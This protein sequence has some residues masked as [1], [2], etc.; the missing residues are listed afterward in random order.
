MTA[1]RQAPYGAW[2]SPV[3][4]DMIAGQSLR[5]QDLCTD[6]TD[7]YWTE[8]R[9]AERGRYAQV[10]CGAD[11]VPVDVP[12][13]ADY[14]MRSLVNAYGGGAFAV[15]SGVVYFVNYRGGGPDPDQRVYRLAGGGSA[16]PLTPDMQG[17]VCYGDLCV[18]TGRNRLL[19]VQQDSTRLN[20]SGQPT[21]S[22]VAV[23]AREGGTP[24]TLVIG[25]D[26]YSSPCV[27]PDGKQLAWLTW[28]YPH[29][30][31]DGSEVWLADIAAD[32]TLRD[33]AF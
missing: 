17:Q 23:D 31:W 33:N 20:P 9:P 4:A 5:F 24:Q 13:S 7:I 15:A 27:S 26:F 21:Q 2:K 29:M 1:R 19:A 18:E 30:P 12:G 6:G 28:N 3:S 22:L 8:S 25:N 11:G 16:H 32:G 14:S 10:R